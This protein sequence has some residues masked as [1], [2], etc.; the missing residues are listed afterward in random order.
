MLKLTK[1]LSRKFV[2]GLMGFLVILLMA[3]KARA[4][5]AVAYFTLEP[6]VGTY[7]QGADFSVLLG[8]NS[9]GEA[10]VGVDVVGTFDATK[11]ELTS[12]GKIEGSSVYQFVGYDASLVQIGASAGTFAVTLTPLGS[13]LY[14]GQAIDG[15]FLRLNFRAKAVGV[16]SVNFTC[17]A[18]SV[19]DSNIINQSALD[20]V[21][22]ASNQSGSYTITASSGDSGSDDSGS[23]ATTAPSPTSTAGEE[24]PQTGGVAGTVGMMVFGIVS[25]MGVLFLKW[26]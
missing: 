10:V 18:G 12:I 19:L 22:C 3:G 14:T 1:E 17:G 16:A 6:A 11:L 13:S 5:E 2:Q 20:I 15:A 24:L 7:E 23:V 8:A 26:L 4:V 9:G 21:E 25:V